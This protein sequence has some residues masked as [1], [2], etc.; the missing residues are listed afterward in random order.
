M[1]YTIT[2]KS[3]EGFEISQFDTKGQRTQFIH[4]LNLLG[5]F[6]YA[7]SEVKG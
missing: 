3:K 1:K 7:L 5:E 6:K 2:V 4:E